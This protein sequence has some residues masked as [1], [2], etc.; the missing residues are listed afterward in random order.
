MI[1]QLF[2]LMTIWRDNNNT[3]PPTRK[4]KIS[5]I[6]TVKQPKCYQIESKT[7]F[8]FFLF[9]NNNNASSCSLPRNFTAVIGAGFMAKDMGF[10]NTAGPE[11]HQ[12]VAL[13]VQSDESIFYN[14]Q[15]DGYQDTLYAHAHRQFYRDCTITG[16][17]DFIF[18]DAAAVFQ[19]CKMLVRKPLENQQ[20]IVT[21]Q[22]RTERREPTGIILQNCTISADKDLYPLR[23]TVRSYLGRPWKEYSRTIIMQTQIDDLIQPQGW[24]PWMGDF[25]L[26]TCFYTEYG[27]R[28]AGSGTTERA[29]WRG[30]KKITPQHA[31][32]FTAGR[33]IGG[34]KWIEPTGVPYTSGLLPQ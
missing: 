33:F 22:G 3:E 14:C 31:A 10:E 26:N 8:T 15:M 6:L 13:R 1:G 23:K 30:V 9:Y 20:C 18:G 21:A 11:K 25:A 29:K 19:N 24:L 4:V 32:D 2:Y 27:N 12:A 28:G 16:T 5:Q 34:D 7:S 17:I